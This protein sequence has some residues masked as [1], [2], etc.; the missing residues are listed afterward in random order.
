MTAE[1]HIERFAELAR[2][3]C[4]WAERESASSETEVE[5]AINYLAQLVA[6]ALEL[7]H[8]FGDEEPKEIDGGEWERVYKRFGSLPFNYY[9]QV[10]NPLPLPPD[11]PV[12]GDLA[13]D[14]ADI[15]RDL[16]KG[17]VL[18]DAGRIQAAVWEWRNG[19]NSHWGR[20]AAGAFF[21]LHCWRTEAT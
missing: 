10:F 8:L 15:W 6:T 4:S 11:E 5:M 14:L 21:A 19:F 12:V 7:P 20:H 18:Y 13:D 17:L 1:E 3:Y 9:S 2:G 16:K